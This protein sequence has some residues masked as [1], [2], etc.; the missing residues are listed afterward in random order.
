MKKRLKDGK[1]KSGAVKKEGP[2]GE[3]DLSKKT[4]LPGMISRLH[5]PMLPPSNLCAIMGLD[6]SSHG[7]KLF[8]VK[9]NDTQKEVCCSLLWFF[10]K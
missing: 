9:R 1:T 5:A 8:Q 7:K 4:R 2:A 10:H 3:E 6:E